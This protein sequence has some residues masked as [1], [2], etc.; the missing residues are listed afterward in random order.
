MKII[1]FLY[2]NGA[3]AQKEVL[4]TKLFLNEPTLTQSKIICEVQGECESTVL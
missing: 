2:E 1:F 4:E 3:V